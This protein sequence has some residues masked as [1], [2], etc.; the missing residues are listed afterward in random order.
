MFSFVLRFVLDKIINIRRTENVQQVTVKFM[1][2]VVQLL[3]VYIY[4]TF[5]FG[6]IVLPIIQMAIT[7]ATK[8]VTMRN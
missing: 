2:F 3:S 5:I 4:L 6:F 7:V 8:F 1:I